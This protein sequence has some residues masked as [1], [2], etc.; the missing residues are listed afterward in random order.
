MCRRYRV[1]VEHLTI[2]R[3][4]PME[5]GPVPR[6][7]SAITVIFVATRRIGAP[8][9]RVGATDH[10]ATAATRYLTAVADDERAGRDSVFRI[11]FRS[12]RLARAVGER[13]T[14][15]RDQ[16]HP[17]GAAAQ[18]GHRIG[19]AAHS[20]SNCIWHVDLSRPIPCQH[21][22]RIRIRS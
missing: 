6:S 12:R 7:E 20:E 21:A 4:A 13:Q 16:N 9:D 8:G 1:L 18:T 3:L 15:P 17:E 19:V 2:G 22:A 5:A 11:D 10:F 14:E